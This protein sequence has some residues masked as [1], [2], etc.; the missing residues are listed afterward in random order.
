MDGILSSRYRAVNETAVEIGDHVTIRAMAVE[1]APEPLLFRV[2]LFVGPQPVQGKPFI[3]S[4][5]FNVKKRSWKGG[6]QVAVAITQSQIDTLSTDND[7]SRW[8]AQALIDLS[9]EDRQSHQ[10]RAHE[11]FIQAV[12]WC[13]LDLALQSG[14]AQEN[15]C[16]ADDTWIAEVRDTVIKRRNFITSYIASELDLVLR[17]VTAP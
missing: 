13:K 3:S 4:C 10:E 16:L 17:N 6:I 12:C 5:V 8:L 2:T 14:I 7:F 15:Q 1:H 9:D 11:L